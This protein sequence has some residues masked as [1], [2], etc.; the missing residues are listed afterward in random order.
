MSRV[1]A[2]RRR[3]RVLAALI[4]LT[5]LVVSGMLVVHRRD[6][7]QTAFAPGSFCLT[8]GAVSDEVAQVERVLSGR[9]SL[10]D[11]TLDAL[12]GNVDI[13]WSDHIASLGPSSLRA[14]ALLVASAVRTSVHAGSP[15][16]LHAEGVAAAVARLAPVAARA[17]GRPTD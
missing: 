14:D 9:G 1:A 17:C 10:H 4:V 2:A 8:F 11:P 7:A 15:D 13:T 16:G 6:P 5:A 12:R 3:E